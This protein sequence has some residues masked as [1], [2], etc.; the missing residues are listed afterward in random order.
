[1]NIWTMLLKNFDRHCV[2][3]KKKIQ[4]C[5][6]KQYP[7]NH[8]IFVFN[9]SIKIDGNCDPGVFLICVLIWG[10]LTGIK[11][12]GYRSPFCTQR[13]MPKSGCIQEKHLEDDLDR[14]RNKSRSCSSLIVQK[15]QEFILL[16]Y[17]L[18]NIKHLRI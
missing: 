7:I 8:F 16:C 4:I 6:K 9:T 3:R 15:S 17:L 2:R 5:N 14:Q 18:L 1:M 12:P 13:R 11:N 10:K